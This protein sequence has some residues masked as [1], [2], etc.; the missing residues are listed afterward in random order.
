MENEVKDGEF[1][2]EEAV[3]RGGNDTAD[4]D[5]STLMPQEREMA[6]KLGLAKKP[7]EK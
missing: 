6:E 3:E 4:V 1:V 2:I 5:I 7:E